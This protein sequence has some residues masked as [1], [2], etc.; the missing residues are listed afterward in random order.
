[1]CRSAG[2]DEDEENGDPENQTHV[3]F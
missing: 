3:L 1:L 2:N